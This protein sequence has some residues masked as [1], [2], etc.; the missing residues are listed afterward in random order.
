MFIRVHPWF[1]LFVDTFKFKLIIAYDGTEYE[2]WQ[3][4]KNG[5]GV[6]QKV[7]EALAKLFPS[8]PRLHSSSRTDTGVHA[9][10]MVAHVEIPSAEFKMPARKLVLAINA[11]LPEDI[12]VMTATRCRA[13]F[14]A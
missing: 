5:T 12:R 6:Q 10:G 8:A 2:G 14:H 9:L 13:D 11:W 4:Q 1:S 3:V 7:E